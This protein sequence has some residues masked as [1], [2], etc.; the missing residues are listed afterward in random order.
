MTRLLAAA[1]AAIALV[2]ATGSEARTAARSRGYWIVLSSNRDGAWR[3][4]SIRPDGSRLTP[5]LARGQALSPSSVSGDGRTIAYNGDRGLYVSRGNGTGLRLVV[6]RGGSSALSRDGKRLAFQLF[7]NR[8]GL[9]VVGT[10]GRGQ[11]RLTT[12]DDNA[13]SW[14]PDGKALVF[15]RYLSSRTGPG[16]DAILVRPLRGKARMLARVVGLGSPG[17]SPDGRWIAYKSS[18]GLNAMQ[19]NGRRLHRVVRGDVSGFAW[20]PDG[21]RLAIS[22]SSGELLVAA[23]DGRV[24]R[25]MRLRDHAT[26]AVS[27]SPDARRLAFDSGTYG[28]PAIS[29]V[30]ADGRG[31]RRLVSEGTSGLV[32]WTRLA[33][34][35]PPAPPIPPSERLVAAGAVATRKPVF[36]LSADGGRVAFAVGAT[37]VDCDHVVVWTPAKKTLTRFQRRALCGEGNNAGFDYDVQLAGSRAA[38]SQT[39]SCGNYCE[40]QLVSATLARRSPQPLAFGAASSSD[41]DY[42]FHLRGAGDLLVFDD[43]SRL[44]RIG[45]GSELCQRGDYDAHI[46]STLR[47][48]SHAVAPDSVSVGLIA[49]REPDVVAV[50]DAKG[51]LVRVFPFA[52]G[53]VTAARLDGGRLFVTRG[54]LLEAYDVSTGAALFQRPLPSG[55]ELE[56][57]DGGIAVLQSGRALTLLRLAGG[58]SFTLTLRG[59]VLADL[60]ADGLYYSYGTAGGGGRVA[61]MP[62]SEVERK[63]GGGAP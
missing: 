12:G 42:D 8:E 7:S 58:R 55:F 13:P 60:E 34:V 48:G 57:V 39:I 32:G 47:R 15:H 24:L 30:G 33:P 28:A 23:V 46:C 19:P 31:L 29:V 6:R 18:A 1:L 61:L 38:W 2:V 9:A 56:D 50:V 54:S 35:R 63:L 41:A 10:D 43:D 4:Y 14:S 16:I 17:W 51:A 52:A 3:P 40:V 20:S 53:D 11:R 36:G 5:L 62:R 25:R 45:G 37:T 59:R 21:R 22:T 44:V 26:G 27:W 49:V